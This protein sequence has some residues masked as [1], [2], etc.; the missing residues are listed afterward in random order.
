M[1]TGASVSVPGAFKI[2]KWIENVKTGFFKR[3][4]GSGMCD[5]SAIQSS[6]RVEYLINMGV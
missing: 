2:H 5:P 4:Q 3:Q 6:N 1:D